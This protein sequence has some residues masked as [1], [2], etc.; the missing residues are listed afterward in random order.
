M[1][2][3]TIIPDANF[4]KSFAVKGVYNFDFQLIAIK[5]V[6]SAI[7]SLSACRLDRELCKRMDGFERLKWKRNIIGLSYLTCKKIVQKLSHFVVALY[8]RSF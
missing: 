7:N 4:N 8:Y 5:A 3:K 1:C 6:C 2:G